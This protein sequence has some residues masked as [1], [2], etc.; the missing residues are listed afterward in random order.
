[1]LTLVRPSQRMVTR[2]FVSVVMLLK[3]PS[4]MLTPVA[5]SQ[6]MPMP[7]WVSM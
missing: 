2:V 7:I 5:T 6:R 1:M 4:L 3:S